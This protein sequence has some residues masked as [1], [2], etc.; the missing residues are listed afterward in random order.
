MSQ[1]LPVGLLRFNG[2]ATM[3]LAQKE[4]IFSLYLRECLDSVELEMVK[5]YMCVYLCDMTL[6][7]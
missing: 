6:H 5:L 3:L 1:T 7:F 4:T 2:V